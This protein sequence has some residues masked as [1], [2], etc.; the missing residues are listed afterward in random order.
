MIV[1]LF[2]ETH[3][4]ISLARLIV[5][6]KKPCC[7]SCLAMS[8]IFRSL[9]WIIILCRCR[10]IFLEGH[11]FANHISGMAQSACKLHA[12]ARYA[13]AYL[14][15]NHE[16]PSTTMACV[17]VQNNPRQLVVQKALAFRIR[18]EH[19]VTHRCRVWTVCRKILF[20]L[21]GCFP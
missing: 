5:P 16:Y 13:C 17:L 21:R 14:S 1:V 9:P 6:Y 3:Q 10:I 12:C 4:I 11:I 8:L 15:S 18:A 20:L 2:R 7:A 19:F